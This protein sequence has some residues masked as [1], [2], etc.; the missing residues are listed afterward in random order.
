MLLT[1]VSNI[2]VLYWSYTCSLLLLCTEF[3]SLKDGHCT[4]TLS[5][6]KPARCLLQYQHILAPQPAS[7][8]QLK[9]VGSVVAL[10]QH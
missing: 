3:S 2:Y 4:G 10:K 1:A 5:C 8:A 9:A 7:T 6:V